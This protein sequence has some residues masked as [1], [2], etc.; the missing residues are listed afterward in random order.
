MT[1]PH[2]TRTGSQ[3][4][5]DYKEWPL[6]RRYEQAAMWGFLSWSDL[7]WKLNVNLGYAPVEKSAR[8]MGVHLAEKAVLRS[9]KEFGVKGNHCMTAASFFWLADQL[10]FGGIGF[11]IKELTPRRV[12]AVQAPYGVCFCYQKEFNIDPM[13]LPELPKLCMS[14][15][16][17]ERTACRLI[18][19]KMK[20]TINK[21]VSRGDGCCEVL[22]E[23]PDDAPI[24][25]HEWNPG[26]R[27]GL[28]QGIYWEE[29]PIERRYKAACRWSSLWYACVTWRLME[30]LGLDKVKQ[31]VIE[32]QKEVAK[33]RYN[34]LFKELSIP[35][36]D[37]GAALTWFMLSEQIGANTLIEVESL[38]P[39]RAVFR[40][41]QP[42]HGGCAL[43][44]PNF[45]V[46]PAKYPQMRSF[47]ETYTAYEAEICRLINPHIRFKLGKSISKG[48]AYCEYILELVD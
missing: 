17:Y 18:N 36:R 2:T 41:L 48:D 14:Y 22:F 12:L 39:K 6:E 31:S 47:C 15:T 32:G 11:I 28:Q 16:D 26:M 30:N 9:L 23:L 4:G 21:L 24:D 40:K 46:N 13:E 8:E 29:W 25:D 45:T 43:H 38:T 34:N 3:M 42:K 1:V 20:Y 27:T 35:D 44:D 10:A 7:F 5:L 37:I 19:P 33:Y